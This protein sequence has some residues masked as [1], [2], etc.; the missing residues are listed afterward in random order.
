MADFLI[1][2][3]ILIQAIRRKQGRWEL[4]HDLVAS[5]G[6]LACSVV[7]LAELYAGMRAHE[8][9]RTDELI[10]EFDQFEVSREIAR[11]AGLLKNEWAQ[12]GYALTLPDMFIAATA[13]A[14]KRTLVS[15]NRK[16]FP[17]SEIRIY[18]IEQP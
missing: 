8:K 9:E 2:T 5:G 15:G 11:Y 1:D 17:M 4:L 10:A 18:P 13:I 7:T 12:K 6:T 14:H 16:H 3:D